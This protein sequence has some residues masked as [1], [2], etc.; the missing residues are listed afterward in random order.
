MSK[1]STKAAAREHSD[2]EGFEVSDHEG[3]SGAGKRKLTVMQW[4]EPVQ[5][6]KS[7]SLFAAPGGYLFSDICNTMLKCSKVKDLSRLWKS[8]LSSKWPRMPKSVLD[9]ALDP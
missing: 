6:L 9:A 2:G 3:G 5:I 1:K 7:N 4:D 8:S